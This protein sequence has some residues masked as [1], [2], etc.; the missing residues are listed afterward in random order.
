MIDGE[1]LIKTSCYRR[2]HTLPIHPI[3]PVTSQCRAADCEATAPRVS[4]LV[5]KIG[6]RTDSGDHPKRNRVAGPQTRAWQAPIP[7]RVCSFA[8]RQDACWL[9]REWVTSSQRQTMVS[10]D[11]RP[12]SSG[13]GAKVLS[14]NL[15]NP[16]IF[17][18]ALK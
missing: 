2:H 8:A 4:N 7:Q 9:T 12:L 6:G 3:P 18:C 15:A 16:S 5:G 10:P 11:G 17:F 13:R 14:R 1:I